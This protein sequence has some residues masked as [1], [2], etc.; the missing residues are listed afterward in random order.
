ME[1]G[2]VRY[3]LTLAAGLLLGWLW[4]ASEPEQQERVCEIHTWLEPPIPRRLDCD[5]TWRLRA[6]NR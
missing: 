5:L 1:G 2:G 6:I 4:R 3:G